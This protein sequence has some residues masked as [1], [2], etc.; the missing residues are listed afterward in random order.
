M[1]ATLELETRVPSERGESTDELDSTSTNEQKSSMPRHGRAKPWHRSQTR[2]ILIVLWT[3]FTI[4]L[5]IMLIVIFVQPQWLGGTN[6]K[7]GVIIN[8]GLYR[9]CS[10]SWQ[11]CSAKLSEFSKI[12][13]SAWK[14][15]TIFVALAICATFLSILVMAGYWLAVPERSGYGFRYATGFQVFTGEF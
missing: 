6:P 11:M 12:P 8:F 1:S 14:T 13:S 7:T 2:N 4:C 10:E 3:I 9:Q 15:A 5:G